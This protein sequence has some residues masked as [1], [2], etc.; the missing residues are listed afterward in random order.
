MTLNIRT[1]AQMSSSALNATQALVE[2]DILVFEGFVE[3]K[4]LY[5]FQ[6]RCTP[7]HS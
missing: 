4:L 5:G 7:L 6:S 2:T 3:L 1:E